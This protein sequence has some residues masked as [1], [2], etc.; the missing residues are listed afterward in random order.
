MLFQAARRG[1]PAE[2]SQGAGARAGRVEGQNGHGQHFRRK[3][4][5]PSALAGRRVAMHAAMRE[6]GGG[7]EETDQAHCKTRRHGRDLCGTRGQ[8]PGTRHGARGDAQPG[9]ACGRRA[10]AGPRFTVTLEEAPIPLLGRRGGD[11]SPLTSSQA[12]ISF[13]QQVSGERSVRRTRVLPRSP[14]PQPSAE[15]AARVPT[16]NL[17]RMRRGSRSNVAGRVH[18]STGL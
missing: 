10:A 2:G 14:P 4:A 7:E 1:G 13:G 3:Y 6:G 15:G 12:G 9:V 11:P 5:G 8:Q 16:N 18:T 17:R